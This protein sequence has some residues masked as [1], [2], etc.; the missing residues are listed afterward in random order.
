MNVSQKT[1][2]WEGIIHSNVAS[3]AMM[4]RQDIY[5]YFPVVRKSPQ[6][7]WGQKGKTTDRSPQVT[8]PDFIQLF[9]ESGVSKWP[10]KVPSLLKHWSK[11]PQPRPTGSSQNEGVC[12]LDRIL[13]GSHRTLKHT[14]ISSISSP[15][16]RRRG[17]VRPLH[18]AYGQRRVP[19]S[20]SSIGDPSQE[21][22]DN[23]AGGWKWKPLWPGEGS[24][25]SW[26]VWTTLNSWFFWKVLREGLLYLSF[27][28]ICVDVCIYLYI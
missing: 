9:L 24:E 4:L 26:W 2:S 27:W 6:F 18:V 23:R 20:G 5:Y 13:L 16:L 15:R 28:Y 21:R 3:C 25:N 8:S 12:G 7:L 10:T 1:I 19:A 22:F 11:G 14:S 17:V